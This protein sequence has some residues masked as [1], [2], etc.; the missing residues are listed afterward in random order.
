MGKKA[1]IDSVDRK[2]L[3]IL[4]KDA[5]TS[6][7]DIAKRIHVS[8]GTVHVRMKRLQRLGVV[9]KA[10]LNVDYSKL[11]YD[12][13]AY[14]GIYLEKGS[15]YTDVIMAL[16]KIPEVVNAHYTTGIY[17]VFVRVICKDTEHL[18]RVLYEKIQEIDGIQRTE[19]FISLEESIYRSLSILEEGDE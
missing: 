10:F 11:G 15:L 6:Y 19:T 18:R 9:K 12:I 13:C 4:M 2:I 5:N 1:D 8:P 14:L 17:S 3:S 7:V 16:Q